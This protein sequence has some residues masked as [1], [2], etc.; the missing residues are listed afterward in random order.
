MD[1]TGKIRKLRNEKGY[2]QEYMAHRLGMSQNGYSKLERGAIQ[3][4]WSK[5]EKIAE[6]LDIPVLEIIQFDEVDTPDVQKRI[7]CLEIEIGLL[8]SIVNSLL[9]RGGALK[10]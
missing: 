5:L 9:S 6:V 1:V 10:V 2:A 8:K 4:T 7:D 3:L